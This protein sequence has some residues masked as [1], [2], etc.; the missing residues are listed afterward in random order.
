MIKRVKRPQAV[1][2]QI[3]HEIEMKNSQF[4]YEQ[5]QKQKEEE[6]KRK[7]IFKGKDEFI[8]IS[9]SQQVIQILTESIDIDLSPIEVEE[10]NKQISSEQL[11][12]INLVKLKQAQRSMK[13]TLSFLCV[14]FL[15]TGYDLLDYIVTPSFDEKVSLNISQY[16]TKFS[17]IAHILF[18]S[19]VDLLLI[20]STYKRSDCCSP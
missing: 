14:A 3:K 17:Y 5:I 15:V 10:L 1:R 19:T 8:N 2:K 11:D 9:A 13:Y 4:I 18:D 7:E 20:L 16:P 6:E 12:T